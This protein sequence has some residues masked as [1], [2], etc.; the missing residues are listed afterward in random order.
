MVIVGRRTEGF[1]P[2]GFGQDAFFPPEWKIP[3]WPQDMSIDTAGQLHSVTLGG[4]KMSSI[5]EEYLEGPGEDFMMQ[6]RETYWQASGKYF[7]YW[8]KRFSKWRIAEISA[9]GNNMDGN[10]FAFVSDGHPGREIRN[11][12]LI[13]GWIEVEDGQWAHRENAG[14]VQV[15]KLS[16]QIEE[17]EEYEE[18]VEEGSCDSTAA[19][20]AFGEE[21]D[22]S[23][24]PV[25]PHVRKAKK[26]VLHAAKAAG[27]WIRRLF[28]NYL[29]APDEEDAIPEEGESNALFEEASSEAV[30]DPT[31]GCQPDTQAGCNFKEKFYVE[32]Q[33]KVTPEK[34]KAE[35]LRLVRMRGV[36]M[37]PDQEEWVNARTSILKK[38]VKKDEEL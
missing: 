35:L 3:K 8:C 20:S 14:V 30:D 23:N 36:T 28:P 10:C 26:K 6:G 22:K 31:E 21:K 15:G 7:M 17:Q 29:G 13:K 32:K 33:Q 37:K 11:K 34:R 24:C 4:F 9:F 5:N 12:S 38:M 1:C 16:E 27:K 2:Q 25:M 18:V 19:G